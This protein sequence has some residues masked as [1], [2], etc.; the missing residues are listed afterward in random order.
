M[1]LILLR[2]EGVKK[3]E[4]LILKVCMWTFFTLYVIVKCKVANTHRA[5]AVFGLWSRNITEF[6]FSCDSS[7]EMSF[8]EK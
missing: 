8:A 5:L 2:V 3:G 4:F 1:G 7:D 6:R